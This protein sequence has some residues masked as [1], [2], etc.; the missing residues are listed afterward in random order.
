MIKIGELIIMSNFN[1]DLFGCMVDMSVC[2]WGTCVPCG[3]QCLQAKAVD[4]ATGQGPL[5]PCLLV[6]CCSCIGGAINRGKIRERYG[7]EGSFVNDCVI[8]W[9]C[10]CC[11][12]CQEYRETKKR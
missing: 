1:E 3:A 6:T 4:K 7:I 2:L 10:G 11:A 9:I 5:V 12:A 8:W